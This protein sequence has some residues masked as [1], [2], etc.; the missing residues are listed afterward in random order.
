MKGTIS[1]PFSLLLLQIFLAKVSF[2]SPMALTVRTSWVIIVTI[3]KVHLAVAV[4]IGGADCHLE[5][6]GEGQG[7]GHQVK[8]K[9]GCVSEAGKQSPWRSAIPSGT[10][11][12]YK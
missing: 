4:G 9:H 11:P 8:Q 6:Q 12:R 2:K 5:M 3:L 10:S 7:S 1:N